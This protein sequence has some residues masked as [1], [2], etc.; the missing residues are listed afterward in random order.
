MFS[1]I[2]RTKFDYFIQAEKLFRSHFFKISL[3]IMYTDHVLAR[4]FS[5]CTHSH[6]P[7]QVYAFL[8]QCVLVTTKMIQEAEYFVLVTVKITQ[9]H[10]VRIYINCK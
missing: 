2:I 3:Q 1:L 8:F 10:Q 7:L 9:T 5:L 6:K 4:L